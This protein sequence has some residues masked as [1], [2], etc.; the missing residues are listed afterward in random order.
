MQRARCHTLGA[1]NAR[2]GAAG[3]D[4]RWLGATLGV[5]VALQLV[6]VNVWP[7]F[8]S[9]NERTRAYQAIAVATRGT[10]EISPELD[11]FGAMEDVA[12]FG[13]RRYPNKAPGVLPLVV[14]GALLAR[15]LAAG[16]EEELALTLVLGRLLAS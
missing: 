4:R 13:G 1:V 5:A 3:S 10:L 15:R 2:A 14:P 11:R 6:V 9:P 16:P 12:A 7:R 8:E